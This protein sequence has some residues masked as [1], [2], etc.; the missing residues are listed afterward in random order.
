VH[1]TKIINVFPKHDKY[2]LD[3]EIQY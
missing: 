1:D 2:L 3:M